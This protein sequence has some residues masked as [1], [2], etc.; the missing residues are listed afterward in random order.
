MSIMKLKHLLLW[1]LLLGM[2][3]LSAKK[4]ENDE[5]YHIVLTLTS[6]ET[7]DGYIRS[8]LMNGAMFVDISDTPKGKYTRYQ[9]TEIEKLV[10]PATETDPEFVWVP[11]RVFFN[12]LTDRI[13]LAMTR[14]CWQGKHVTCYAIPWVDAN[15]V[16]GYGGTQKGMNYITRYNYYFS[17]DNRPDGMTDYAVKKYVKDATVDAAYIF[18]LTKKQTLR[19][20]SDYPEIQ[21]LIRSKKV[22]YSEWMEL[23]EA[24]DALLDS[25]QP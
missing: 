17:T 22:K 15:P 11:R 14:V 7:I 9:T 25:Q 21:E 18:S 16:L 23:M 6:G 2:F 20:L 8:S 1:L 3:D 24:L 13:R 4:K 10:Y 12:S 19:A 5:D